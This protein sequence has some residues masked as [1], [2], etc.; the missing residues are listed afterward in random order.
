MEYNINYLTLGGGKFLGQVLTFGLNKLDE[1]YFDLYDDNSSK[2]M[3]REDVFDYDKKIKVQGTHEMSFEETANCQNLIF[4]NA[5]SEQS[6]EKINER[7]TYIE[8]SMRSYAMRNLKLKY[9]IECYKFLLRN[10]TKFF[11]FDYM[12]FWNKDT[13]LKQTKSLSDYFN[14][15]FDPKVLSYAHRKWIKSNL[16]YKGK[17]K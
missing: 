3:T 4:I 6:I 13:F 5:T 9:H 2:W 17:A 14:F 1:N 15:Q 7:N 10:K 8:T 16:T 11:D 12:S